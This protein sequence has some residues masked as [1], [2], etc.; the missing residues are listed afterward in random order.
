MAVNAL[1]GIVA[2][3]R[4]GL[5]FEELVGALP[6]VRLGIL[7]TPLARAH[8][9][10]RTVG[11]GPLLVKRDDLAG[12]GVAGNKTRPLEFLLGEAR[13]R[14]AEVLVT[15]GGPGSNFCPA[16]AMAAS[17]VGLD[18]ELVVWGEPR[19]PNLAL[20]RA[21]GARLLP[22]GDR[23]RAAVDELVRRRAAELTS[24]GRRAYP[25]PR[26]GSTPLGAVGFALAAA[27]LARQLAVWPTEWPELIVLPVGSGG[28]CAG[29]LAG[30]I[31]IGL[32]IP[33]L[34]VS[35]SRPPDQVH[36][37]VRELAAG[38][39]RLLGI[40]APAASLEILLEI[41]DARGP[42]FGLASELERERALRLF[43]AEGLPLD[44]TYG[45]ET[46]SAAL[47]RARTGPV[48]FWH[49]GGLIP[50]VTGITE[51]VGT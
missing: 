47:D 9:I 49:T 7:P 51:G 20:A 32:D 39:A 42:G 3:N 10:E 29:L 19:G 38:C 1:T 23:D 45:A 34:G 16:A 11:G 40:E 6:R 13:A 2:A 44:A 25:V 41:V 36:A 50:A 33:V 12:F 4:S 28:S 14:G 15:G 22:T 21:A 31:A 35:V 24:A 37:R 30:L 17:A 27:E 46:W 43:R 8:R 48:L 5:P 18:C 26:G